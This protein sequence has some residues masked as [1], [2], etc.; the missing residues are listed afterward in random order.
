MSL[1]SS[2]AAD[3]KNTEKSV[4]PQRLQYR[5]SSYHAIWAKKWQENEKHKHVKL[6]LHSIHQQTL[7]QLTGEEKWNQIKP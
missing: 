7:Q 1:I 3:N 4:K 6:S 5:K 2:P